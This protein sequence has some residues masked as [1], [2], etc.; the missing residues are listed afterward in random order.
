M[1]TGILVTRSPP[2]NFLQSGERV[3]AIGNFESQ[4]RQ[5]A[6]N[7]LPVAAAMPYPFLIP[8]FYTA[9]MDKAPNPNAAALLAGY[10]ATP[11]G[12]A[13][14]R[15]RNFQGDYRKGS[16]D[17]IAQ[18]IAKSGAPVIY[19][20]LGEIAKRDAMIG[21]ANSITAGQIR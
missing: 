2:E 9:A 21:K 10:L 17:P 15:A 18:M 4:A 20:D 1:N 13:A 19:D 11:E 8:Q 6:R 3:Y 7:G 14:G 12:I 5:W 16:S